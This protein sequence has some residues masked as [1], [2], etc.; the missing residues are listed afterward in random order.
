MQLLARVEAGLKDVTVNVPDYEILRCLRTAHCLYQPVNLVLPADRYLDLQ[1]RLAFGYNKWKEE[2]QLIS[3]FSDINAYHQRLDK[4]ELKDAQIQTLDISNGLPFLELLRRLLLLFVYSLL[5]AP[6]FLLFSPVMAFVRQRAL[7]ESHKAKK[8]SSV[9]LLGKDVIASQKILIGFVSFPV[10]VVIYF[11]IACY[12][13]GTWYGVF[14]LASLPLFAYGTTKISEQLVL[15]YTATKPLLL[16]FLS[17]RFRNSCCELIETRRLLQRK[18]RSAIESLGPKT[19][20]EAE[21]EWKDRIVK[22]QTLMGDDSAETSPGQIL[23]PQRELFTHEDV[24][25]SQAILQGL[26]EEFL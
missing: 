14:F 16:L 6:C 26:E 3:L 10:A 25:S 8:A 19:W 11:A 4:E 1:R 23:W 7:Y 17:D 9:K 15:L 12:F 18:V 21:D 24:S 22:P 13:F 20:S 5:V 2:P